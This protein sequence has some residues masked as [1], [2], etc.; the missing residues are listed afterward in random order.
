MKPQKGSYFSLECSRRGDSVPT[1]MR[2]VSGK[3]VIPNTSEPT[4][5][6]K[7]LRR[8]N[9][10]QSN[11]LVPRMVPEITPPVNRSKKAFLSRARA[12]E[13]FGHC[14]GTIK[15]GNFGHHL[16]P[17]F[18]HYSGTILAG[19]GHRFCPVRLLKPENRNTT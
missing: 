15:R 4:T 7:G 5:C 17:P 9:L 2:Q 6:T 12:P 19:F 14:S 16:G 13:N 1:S 18:G 10:K 8:G 3:K 11:Q